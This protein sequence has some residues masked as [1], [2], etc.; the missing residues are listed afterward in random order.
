MA[1]NS[2]TSLAS[3]SLIIPS[4]GFLPINSN[5]QQLV[6]TTSNNSSKNSTAMANSCLTIHLKSY[7]THQTIVISKW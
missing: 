6:K 2:S 7:P 3:S 4:Y 5:Y 1:I